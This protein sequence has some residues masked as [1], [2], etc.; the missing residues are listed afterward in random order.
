[1]LLVSQRPIFIAD[2]LK[3]AGTPFEVDASYA[4]SLIDRGVAHRAGTPEILYETSTQKQDDAILREQGVT[5][6][7]LTRNRR[8]WLKQAIDSYV[9]QTFQPRELLIIADGET[10]SDLIPEREDIRLIHIEEGRTIGEKRNCGVVNARGKVDAHWDDDDYSGPD[11]IH[12]QMFRLQESGK[13]V[14][15]YSQINFTD[16]RD[17][18]QYTGDSEFAPGSS[19]AYDRVWALANPFPPLQI[20]EDGEFIRK[21]R[22]L[23]QIATCPSPGN[24]TATIHPG[25]TS[26]RILSLQYWT[27]MGKSASGLTVVIPSRNGE[28]VR[29]CISAV[30][31][32]DPD[33]R[34]IVVDDGLFA[35]DIVDAQVVQGEKPF[36]FSRNVNIGIQA[37]GRDDVIVLNDDALLKSAGGFSLLK[38]AVATHPEFGIIGAVSDAVGNR[39]QWPQRIGLREDPRMV[40]FVAVFIPRSTLDAVGGL[41][42]RFTAYGFEDDDYCYRVR[43]AG[44]K[45]GVHDDCFVDH[46]SLRST[47][48]G[49]PLTSA[50]LEGGRAIFERKW[51]SYPL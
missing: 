30:R 42:E 29:A 7:C 1:M 40:C 28:N 20:N 22:Q 32:M 18:W 13:P 12:D 5:C 23:G 48:R 24:L 14:V 4:Q 27:P 17:W 50:Q 44:L 38:Q 16:G 33:I 35:P 9:A 46:T 11:R 47:F 39:G 37:A 6:L 15:G 34:I 2:E 51:G 25:N 36:I 43:R 31:A 45:I 49:D 10:V 19:L 21:A 26:P 8:D 41:D 3:Y